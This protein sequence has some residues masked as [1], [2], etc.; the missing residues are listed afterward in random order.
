VRR[1]HNSE[2]TADMAYTGIARNI[3]TSYRCYH[4]PRYVSTLS[5][6]N[7]PQPLILH[8]Y[9][10]RSR[11]HS[12]SLSRIHI[13]ANTLHLPH[14][15]YDNQQISEDG[16]GVNSETSEMWVAFPNPTRL[17]RAR[18]K[19]AQQPWSAAPAL[20]QHVSLQQGGR[21]M[22]TGSAMR[23]PMPSRARLW[24]QEAHLDHDSNMSVRNLLQC[25]P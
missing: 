5:F 16:F 3:V 7:C 13:C 19:L 23:S 22:T 8:G 14:P 4:V 20:R 6:T 10:T 25:G 12:T 11:R 17:G 9:P 1:Y 18:S 24:I 2:P 15:H 21:D